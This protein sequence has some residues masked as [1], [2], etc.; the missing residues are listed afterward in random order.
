MITIFHNPKCSKFRQTLEL[1]RQRHLDPRVVN[2]LE[3]PP[4]VEELRDIL[5]KLGMRP[6]ELLRR[7]ET[8]CVELGLTDPQ[9]SDEALIRAMSRH[10]IVIER[11]IVVT[12]TRAALGRPPEQVLSIL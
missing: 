4:T 6:R 3:T 12:A 8:A 10:P 7:Q 1:L 5:R 11:P 2:Y 9:L